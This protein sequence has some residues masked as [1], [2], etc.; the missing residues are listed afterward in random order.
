M[1]SLTVVLPASMWAMIPMFRIRARSVFLPAGFLD[2]GE[3]NSRL[4]RRRTLKTNRGGHR[5]PP[6]LR[7]ASPLPG[8]VAE[9]L[10]RL[11]HL[12]DVLALGERAALALGRGDELL[13]ERD[14]ER[15][16]AAAAARD[17][18][19]PAERERLLALAAHLDRDLVVRAADAPA[20]H[21]DH[22]LH[23]LDR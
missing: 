9:R 17:L 22:R 11:G 2:M 21:L 20:A 4:S 12:V 13:R 7:N 6:R 10:V 8:E 3:R 16:A 23:V 19:D 1:R 15:T 14:R 5:C 18:E